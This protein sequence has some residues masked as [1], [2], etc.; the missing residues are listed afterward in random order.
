MLLTGFFQFQSL[1]INE[2]AK[3]AKMLEGH[4]LEGQILE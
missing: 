4:L 2:V 3:K 1:I